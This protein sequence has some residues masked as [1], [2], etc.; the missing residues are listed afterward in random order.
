MAESTRD[1][2]LNVNGRDYTV[3]VPDDMPLLWV[4]RDLL[5]LKGTKFDAELLNAARV[6]CTWMDA[7]ADDANAPRIGDLSYE[8]GAGVNDVTISRVGSLLLPT[9]SHPD[10]ANPLFVDHV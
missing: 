8:P 9:L 10:Q 7:I 3:Q 6:P 4:L 2:S 5:G 1:V